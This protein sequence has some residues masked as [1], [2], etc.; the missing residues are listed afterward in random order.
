MN[1]GSEFAGRGSAI[2]DVLPAKF[3]RL[4]RGDLSRLRTA[5]GARY[6][7]GSSER[8]DLTDLLEHEVGKFA[9]YRMPDAR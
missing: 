4:T 8:R 6:Y 7:L 1:G 3:L 2:C 5:Y 9:I